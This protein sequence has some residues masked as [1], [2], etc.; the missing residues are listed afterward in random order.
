[1]L[2]IA[3]RSEPRPTSP[4]WDR[5]VLRVQPRRSPGLDAG[6]GSPLGC[7]RERPRHSKGEH[8]W[9]PL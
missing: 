5:R 4:V 3:H 7:D 1:M 8:E 6:S 2:R 9:P